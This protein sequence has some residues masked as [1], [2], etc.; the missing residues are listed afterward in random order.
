MLLISA[1]RS[2]CMHWW[3]CLPRW[4][5][6]ALQNQGKVLNTSSWAVQDLRQWTEGLLFC[7]RTEG[8]TTTHCHFSGAYEDPLATTRTALHLDWAQQRKCWLYCC[9][10]GNYTD[11]YPFVFLYLV[12]SLYRI[13]LFLHNSHVPLG[14]PCLISCSHLL[15][16]H[17]S[18]TVQGLIC[19]WKFS[20]EQP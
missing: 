7:Q 20:S 9:F 5:L 14:L 1:S 15:Y 12:T 18:Q 19:Y 3:N 10:Q 4:G 8:W 16:F 17:L 2:R 11:S 6:N 13:V